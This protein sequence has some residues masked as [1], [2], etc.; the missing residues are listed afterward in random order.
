MIRIELASL[1]HTTHRDAVVGLYREVFGGPVEANVEHLEEGRASTCWL[2]FDGDLLVGLKWATQRKRGELHSNLGLVRESHRRQGIARALM[3]AQHTWAREQGYRKV[4]ST[5]FRANA[6][7][8]LL[9][10]EVG[11]ELVGVQWF[12][13]SGAGAPS[14]LKLLL[15]RDLRAEPAPLAHDPTVNEAVQTAPTLEVVGRDALATAV[16]AGFRVDGLHVRHGIPT[17]VVSSR[18]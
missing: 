8:L 13:G 16:R 1:P 6:P 15:E 9:D 10:L 11:F 7:M 17:V 3:H 4:T 14:D 5:T 18:A 12:E 2:A